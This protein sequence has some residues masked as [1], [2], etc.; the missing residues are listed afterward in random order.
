M[1]RSLNKLN[2]GNV[3]YVYVC[4]QLR[5]KSGFFFLLEW[6][7]DTIRPNCVVA[8]KGFALSSSF[9][10]ENFLFKKLLDGIPSASADTSFSTEHL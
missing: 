2:C 8:G 3:L 9:L 1:L 6:D 5:E 10:D 4:D 7:G